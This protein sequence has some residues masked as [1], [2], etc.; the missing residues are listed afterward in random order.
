MYKNEEETQNQ[1]KLYLLWVQVCDF[2]YCKGWLIPYIA[3]STA[4]ILAS[5]IVLHLFYFVTDISM[6]NHMAQGFKQP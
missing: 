3:L 2:I 1:E 4:N 5:F 6:F